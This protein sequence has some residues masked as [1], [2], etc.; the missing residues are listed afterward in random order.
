M[1][2]DVA[3]AQRQLGRA[4]DRARVGED[5]QLATEVREKGEQLAM[6]LH[7]LL[8]MS[9]IHAADNKAFDR[10]IEEL[11]VVLKRLV[12]LLG[13]VHLATVEDQVY[14]NDIRIR[15]TSRAQPGDDLGAEL[16]RHNVGGLTFHAP[17]SEQEMR[18]LVGAFSGRPPTTGRRAAVVEALARHGVSSV[19]PTGVYRFRMAGEKGGGTERRA[20]GPE[21]VIAHA[22][23]L[24]D[25]T[26]ANVA[27]HRML[28]PLPLRR[29]V[30]ELLGLDMQD[31]AFWLEPAAGSEHA[32][33]AARVCRLALLIGR[34]LMLTDGVLQDLGIAA[35]VHDI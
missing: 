22:V 34:G 33:H 19:E 7:G 31:E 21:E 15:V 30:S 16:R 3:S 11:Q 17:L 32:R 5:R 14:V 35:L 29:V 6:T 10:P 20:R 12:E 9:R 27:E 4:F 2:D 25:E 28:N 26:L 13:V 8:R 18:A 1:T 24:V 23:A